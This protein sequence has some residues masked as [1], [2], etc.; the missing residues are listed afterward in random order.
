MSE[1]VF[2]YGALRRG[3][4]NGWRMKT[5]RWIG[6]AKIRGTLIRVDWYPGL[7]LEGEDFVIGEVYEVDPDLLRQLDE[8]EG[9]APEEAGGGNG[10]Y[11]RIRAEVT[12]GAEKRQV[13]LYEWR[14]GTDGYELVQSGDW[15][16]ASEQEPH[17]KLPD[18]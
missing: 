1:E 15:L 7:V 12:L 14:K 16:S 13:W 5:A 4:S 2:V 11:R 10:E 17:R 9:L 6:E 3:A 18:A 8:F